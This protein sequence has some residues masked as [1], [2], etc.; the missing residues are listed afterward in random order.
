MSMNQTSRLS[1]GSLVS[2]KTVYGAR[3]TVQG[4]R[5]KAEGKA[6]NPH[7]YL[8]LLRN[9]LILMFFSFSF[10]LTNR[11]KSGVIL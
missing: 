10:T 4:F 11:K 7:L 8:Q 6:G 9:M 3:F 1:G 2:E 5:F